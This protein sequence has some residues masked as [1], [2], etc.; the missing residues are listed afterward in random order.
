ML[1]ARAAFVNPAI[2]V[3][4][5]HAVEADL[6]ALQR[7]RVFFAHQSV[8][9]N[10]L[11]GL[12]TLLR[13]TGRELAI[14]EWGGEPPVGGAAEPPSVIWHTKVG[15][16]EQPLTKCDEFRRLMDE[17]LATRV[18]VALLKF[19]Y[20]DINERTDA[21]GLATRYIETLDDLAR[22]HPAV[23]M[24]PVTAPL[25]QTPGGL[26]VLAREL[27]GR[28]NR[29]K[30]DNRA[31]H[32]FNDRVRQ[33]YAGRPLFDLA[34]AQ[35]TRPDGRRESFAADGSRIDALAAAYTDDGGHLNAVG[36]PVIA[37]ALLRTLADA[38]RRRG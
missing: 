27:L 21:E 1:W 14:V 37:A 30:A 36:Q 7:A 6:D 8:G 33:A 38:M 35:A 34:A 20:I 24:L 3:G 10:I 15:R 32:R 13:Q 31:R 26:G 5:P 29:S 22:R 16:N 2:M 11:A 12:R 19:C 18:D 23:T 17:G 9:E 4:M 25:R 28:P